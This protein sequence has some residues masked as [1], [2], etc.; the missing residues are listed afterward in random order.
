MSLRTRIVQRPGCRQDLSGATSTPIYQTATFAFS[1]N[2]SSARFDYSRSGNPTRRIL[3][4]KVADLESAVGCLSYG[5]GMSALA[6]IFA[7]VPL[8]GRLVVS[9]DLYGG[10]FRLL[11][12]LKERNLANVVFIDTRDL[13][14]VSRALSSQTDLLLIESPSNPLHQVTDIRQ[15]SDICR[16]R[17]CLLACDNS[18]MSP[19][20]QRP[21]EL[22]ADLV[23]ESA[24][25]F[26]GGHGDVTA[27][28]VGWRA[29]EIG[30]RL[31]FA[32]NAL[33]QALGPMDAWFLLRGL[34]TL[35]VRIDAQQKSAKVIAE[36]LSKNQ[37]V[38]ELHFV[39]L[40]NHPGY[41]L[42]QSQAEGA[43]AVLSFEVEDESIA[44]N[45]LSFTRLFATTVSFGSTKSTISLPHGM[46]HGSIP[47][48]LKGKLGP[49]NNLLRI[50]IGLEDPEDLME[51][52]AQAL[53]RSTT[54]LG[55]NLR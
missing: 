39:G 25:K 43:G 15:V 4:E 33:G 31:A 52:L 21:L 2:S 22:G 10:S 11:S 45:V 18:I 19:W 7:L 53:E 3:E 27:G 55:A 9:R 35:A 20:L 30:D 17:D 44:K 12:D 24:T 42:H 13:E 23:I 50:S 47:K 14:E 36:A 32:H 8:G 41:E 54:N 51:D 5:S 48:H 37:D 26:L 1:E 46:S 28:I 6:A 29:Q 49:P 16:R 38:R 34:E 40:P